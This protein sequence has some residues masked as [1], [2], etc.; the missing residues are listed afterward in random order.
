MA[1]LYG[2]GILA[3]R[4]CYQL[5]YASS[6][7]DAGDRATRR[8][9]RLRARLGWEPGILN[10]NGDKPKWMRWRT[11]YRLTAKHNQLVGRSMHAVALKFGWL[12]HD[13]PK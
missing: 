2:G 5:V 11:F 10:G 9:H 4:D 6:R 12:G 8:A 1:I 3:C 13:F 7:E